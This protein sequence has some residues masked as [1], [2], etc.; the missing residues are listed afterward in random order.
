MLIKKTEDGDAGLS[1]SRVFDFVVS[2][3]GWLNQKYWCSCDPYREPKYILLESFGC[4]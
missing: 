4:A 2:N 1:E 3:F